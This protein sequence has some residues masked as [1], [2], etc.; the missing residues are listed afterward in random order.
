MLLSGPLS[1]PETEEKEIGRRPYSKKLAA[2]IDEEARFLVARAYKKTEALLLENKD[3]LVK[4]SIAKRKGFFSWIL[5]VR[6]ARP[7]CLAQVA[8]ALLTREVLNYQD[9]EELIGPPRY[10]KKRLV[11]PIQFE[12]ELQQQGRADQE[13]G[14]AD[15]EHDQSNQEPKGENRSPDRGIGRFTFV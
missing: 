11:E 2:V 3:K 12:L 14:R 5:L 6:N 10:P 9:M 15:H 4:V 8:E 7:A 1:Y 13:Q